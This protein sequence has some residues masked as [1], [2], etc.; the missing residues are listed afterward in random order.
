M[1]NSIA[2]PLRWANFCTKYCPPVISFWYKEAQRAGIEIEGHHEVDSYMIDL[3]NL[4]IFEIEQNEPLPV[5]MATWYEFLTLMHGWLTGKDGREL[6]N[7]LKPDLVKAVARSAARLSSL[8]AL[9][10]NVTA[11]EELLM[12][13]IQV[14]EHERPLAEQHGTFYGYFLPEQELSALYRSKSSAAKNENFCR[15]TYN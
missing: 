13:A 14:V 8:H 4:I 11:Q 9:T 5:I 3:Y 10:G 1:P 12:R 7:D 15:L 6:P 2:T